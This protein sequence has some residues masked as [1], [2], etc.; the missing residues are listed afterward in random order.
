[1]DNPRGDDDVFMS[2]LKNLD[3]SQLINMVLGLRKEVASITED[4]KK[5]M[6]LRFYH[7]ERSHYM[8]LQYGR[9]DTVEIT[10]IPDDVNDDALED[11]VIDLFKE[12][13]VHVNRQPI[14]KT[15]IQAVHRLGN[16]KTT[17]VKVV[18]RKFAKEAL[19]CGKNLKGSK[20]YGINSPIY[21]NDSFC[22]EYNFLNFAIRK[23]YKSKHILK[24]KVRNGVNYVQKDDA[25][26]F[27]EVGHVFDLE[28]L[29]IPI[30]PRKNH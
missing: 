28:N 3:K 8:N 26:K 10:G 22:P 30:P 29:K 17:I 20:R 11:E 18:N 14:K 12:A 27:V 4:F 1:M 13:K 7:L 5:L 23:A 21:I 24:Y 6:N 9:R 15:D 19:F 2:E 16:K 25:S